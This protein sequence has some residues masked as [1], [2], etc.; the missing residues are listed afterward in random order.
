ML[1]LRSLSVWV[2]LAVALTGCRSASSWSHAKAPTAP[3][4]PHSEQAVADATKS[5][6]Q[7]VGK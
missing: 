1:C 3:R 4:Y 6:Q 5:S 7:V 2:A